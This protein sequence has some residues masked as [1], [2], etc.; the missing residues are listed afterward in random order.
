MIMIKKVYKDKKT[1]EWEREREDK[2]SKANAK[3]TYI[4]S[5]VYKKHVN[6]WIF[7]IYFTLK[8]N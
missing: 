6:S 4:R 1:K 5:F 7:S 8:P 2:E 3:W